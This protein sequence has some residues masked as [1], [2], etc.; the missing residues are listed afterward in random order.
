MSG[1]TQSTTADVSR[2]L[3][4]AAARRMDPAAVRRATDQAREFES[5]FVGQML[6]QMRTETMKNTGFDGGHA[7]EQWRGMMN[8]QLAKQI[9]SA[10]GV[11]ISAQVARELL[12]TQE[13]RSDGLG[14]NRRAPS[15]PPGAM[16]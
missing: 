3:T 12:R 13:T 15:I 2:I 9:T 10:G 11:G 7:E 4:Q 16:R 14:A 5:V 6:N 1:Q 8:E